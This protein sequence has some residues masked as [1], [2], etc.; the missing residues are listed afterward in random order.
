MSNWITHTVT[1]ADGSKPYTV[2]ISD[3]ELAKHG[4]PEQALAARAEA[5]VR[6]IRRD[7][8]LYGTD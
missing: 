2:E 8:A 1:P 5:H 7:A 3:H 4:S 6:A